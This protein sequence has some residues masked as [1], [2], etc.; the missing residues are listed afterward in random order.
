MALP[1]YTPRVGND[2]KS[3]MIH[4]TTGTG[5]ARLFESLGVRALDG[6]PTANPSTY[7][8]LAAIHQSLDL[9]EF[10]QFSY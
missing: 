8:L 7:E 2:P 3:V 10:L 1:D 4:L 9:F 5:M 6:G